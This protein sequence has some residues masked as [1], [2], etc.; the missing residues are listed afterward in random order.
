MPIVTSVPNSFTN[1]LVA[2]ATQVNADFASLVS[3][4]NAGAA[5][6]GANVSITS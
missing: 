3:Q 1:G 6:S 2:D 4:I 5:E